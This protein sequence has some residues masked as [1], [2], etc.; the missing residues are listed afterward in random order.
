MEDKNHKMKKYAK[1]RKSSEK[2]IR[3]NNKKLI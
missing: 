3:K 2:D 1:T